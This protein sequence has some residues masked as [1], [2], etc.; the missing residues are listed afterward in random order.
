MSFYQSW[1]PASSFASTHHRVNDAKAKSICDTVFSGLAAK[2]CQE[3]PAFYMKGCLPRIVKGE[4][5]LQCDNS[6]ATLK[7]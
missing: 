1:A 2:I 3:F 7:M 6:A 5:S 4:L